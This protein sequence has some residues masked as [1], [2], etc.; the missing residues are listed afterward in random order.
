MAL[1]TYSE[2]QTSVSNFL[3]RDD[4]TAVIPDFI[5]LAE[6]QINRD[7]RHWQMQERS[8][9]DLAEQYLTRPGDW[10]ETI[11]FSISL[12]GYRELQ[13]ITPTDMQKR[14]GLA[15]DA[16]GVPQ[17]FTYSQDEIEV[18]PTPDQTYTAELIYTKKIAALSDSNTSNW[19]LADAPDVYL[20]GALMHSAPYLHDDARVTI[21][22]SLYKSAVDSLNIRSDQSQYSNTLLRIGA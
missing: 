20:Y 13:Y 14:R 12:N 16:S 15:S 21:W 5:A 4:L 7:L 11:R 10:L 8:T 17:Y 3:N 2:L 6:A 22:A 9:S 18:Y 19:L 1:S